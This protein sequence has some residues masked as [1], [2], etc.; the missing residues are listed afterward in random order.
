[1]LLA[2]FKGNLAW[3]PAGNPASGN[4][5]AEFDAGSIACT[6]DTLNP[7]GTGYNGSFNIVL[8]KPGGTCTTNAGNGYAGDFSTG[9]PGVGSD[10]QNVNPDFVDQNRGLQ[11]A[12]INFFGESAATAWVSGTAYTG[13]SPVPGAGPTVSTAAAGYY[14]GITINWQCIENHT[15]SSTN[16]PGAANGT[17]RTYWATDRLAS[18]FTWTALNAG[19]LS[20]RFPVARIAPLMP[21]S[22]NGF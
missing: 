4:L 13:C 7:L 8:T 21:L 18:I 12:G 2:V 5:Y 19:T 16:M 14:G 1:M 10:V 20:T 15:A 9:P 17:W 22:T 6:P 3:Q 11:Q